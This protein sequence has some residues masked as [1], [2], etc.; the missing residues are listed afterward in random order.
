MSPST[1]L[2]PHAGEAAPWGS[3]VRRDLL[4]VVIAAAVALGLTLWL[5]EQ[6]RRVPLTVANDTDYELTIGATSPG[7]D[8]WLPILV[9]DPHQERARAGTIDQGPEWVFRFS[10]QGRD[11]GQVTISREQLAADGWRFEVPSEVARRLEAQG[12]TPPPRAG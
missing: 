1:V 6:P 8:S 9:I 10:G 7:D 5:V 3:S 11:G 2:R 12:A 4:S